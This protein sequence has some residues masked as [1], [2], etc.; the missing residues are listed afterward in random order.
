MQ[1]RSSFEKKE[2]V[3]NAKDRGQRH[4]FVWERSWSTWRSC[5]NSLRAVYRK[6]IIW[7]NLAGLHTAGRLLKGSFHSCFSGKRCSVH[8]RTLFSQ[9]FF[10]RDLPPTTLFTFPPL[11]CSEKS[12]VKGA[13]WDVGERRK[14]LPK[15]KN[16]LVRFPQVTLF[17]FFAAISLAGKQASAFRKK[18]KK[19]G[20][21]RTE[22][23]K[24]A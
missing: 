3:G 14:S 24:F 17:L 20:G 15:E 1:Q 13:N 18:P 9:T 19:E 6:S 2:K 4:L 12:K 11:R 10:D 8:T 23:R 5:L 21:R 22:E 16:R 7:E